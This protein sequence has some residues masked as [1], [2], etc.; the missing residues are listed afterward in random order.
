MNPNIKFTSAFGFSEVHKERV[1]QLINYLAL[2]VS[3]L[4]VTKLIKLLYIIDEESI[5][6]IGTPV[7]WLKYKVYKMGPV[8]EDIWFSVKDGNTVFGD[9]FDVIEKKS[10]RNDEDGICYKINPISPADLSE[11]SKIEV[12]IINFVIEKFGSK[13]PK[14][15][16]KHLHRKESLWYK[17]VDENKISFEEHLAT[18]YIIDLSKLINND[19]N[20]LNIYQDAREEINLLESLA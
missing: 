7:T 16:I 10:E 2:K 13:T 19:P 12:K 4:Y 3:G 11:F 6:K 5:M 20:M 14:N 18:S 9:Y 1:G 15:L 8:T 17:I